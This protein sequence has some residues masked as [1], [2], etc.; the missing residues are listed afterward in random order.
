MEEKNFAYLIM[1]IVA[2]HFIVGIGWLM[3]KMNK[4]K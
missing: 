2:L 3:Y 1:A 4:K